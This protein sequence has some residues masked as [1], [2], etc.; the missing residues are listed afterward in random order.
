MSAKNILIACGVFFVTLSFLV[1][2]DMLPGPAVI[3]NIA[4]F[5]ACS[6]I[7]GVIFYCAGT[8]PRTK[9]VPGQIYWVMSKPRKTQFGDTIHYFVFLSEGSPRVTEANVF[10]YKL[11][12]RDVQM[13]FDTLDIGIAFAYEMRGMIP[14]IKICP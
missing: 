2:L 11:H 4:G 1:C 6:L 14:E 9:L 7:A 10:A 5:G 12:F 8:I 3:V 13:D